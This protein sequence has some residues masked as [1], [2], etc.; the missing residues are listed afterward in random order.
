VDAFQSIE[1]ALKMIGA[2]LGKLNREHD[3][4]LRWEGDERGDF[5]FPI[6]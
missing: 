5:G 2:E 6:P 4:Q 1:L 3:G